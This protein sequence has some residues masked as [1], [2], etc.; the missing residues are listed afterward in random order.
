VSCC[1]CGLNS[2]ETEGVPPQADL[3]S[4]NRGQRLRIPKI[5]SRK[6]PSTKS[7]IT[8][9]FQLPKF[10]IQNKKITNRYANGI[11][12]GSPWL[13]VRPSDVEGFGH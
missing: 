5:L 9:K 13:A 1:G 6:I 2:K 10:K 3:V 7:Q 4:G 8:N 12:T 11:R